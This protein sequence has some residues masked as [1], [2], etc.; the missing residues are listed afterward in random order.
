MMIKRYGLLSY[1]IWNQEQIP[2]KWKQVTFE[3]QKME[4]R[5]EVLAGRFINNMS[6]MQYALPE[7]YKKIQIMGPVKQT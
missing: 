5:G 2:V 3:L 4:A 7:A 6:G 1:D